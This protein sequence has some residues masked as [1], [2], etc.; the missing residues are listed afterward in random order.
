[1]HETIL[2]EPAFRDDVEGTAVVV[3]CIDSDTTIINLSG[4]FDLGVREL[5]LLANGTTLEEE[6][7]EPKIDEKLSRRKRRKYQIRV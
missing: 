1:M 7:L 3:G 5:L 6:I 2:N 4:S